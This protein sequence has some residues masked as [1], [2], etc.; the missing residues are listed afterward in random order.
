MD[1]HNLKWWLKTVGEALLWTGGYY[2][3]ELLKLFPDNTV[4]DQIAVPVGFLVGFLVRKA[5]GTKNEYKQD[6]LPGGITKIMDKIPDSI[7]GV[8]GSEKVSDTEKTNE[9]K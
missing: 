3:T 2:T 9:I 1:S 5:I 8:R 4:A 7:T 6:T